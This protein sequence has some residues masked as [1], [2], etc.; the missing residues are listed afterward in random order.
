MSFLIDIL[1]YRLDRQ[2]GRVKSLVSQPYQTNNRYQALV[3][4]RITDS[5]DI[6]SLYRLRSAY[7]E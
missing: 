5:R 7:D 6:V 3:G 4:I 1:K 2:L